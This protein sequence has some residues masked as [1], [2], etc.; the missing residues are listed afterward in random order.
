MDLNKYQIAGI[1]FL[2]I[3]TVMAI[4]GALTWNTDPR[5]TTDT[6]L[7]YSAIPCG[8]LGALLLKFGKVIAD[9]FRLTNGA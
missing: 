5:E 8:V 9:H 6:A 1:I 7:L 3:G 2:I 4:G